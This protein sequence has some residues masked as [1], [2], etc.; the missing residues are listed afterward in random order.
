MKQLV[1][2]KSVDDVVRFATYGLNIESKLDDNPILYFYDEWKLK[3]D[4]IPFKPLTN[5]E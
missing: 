5:N 4:S 3:S 2:L 1:P